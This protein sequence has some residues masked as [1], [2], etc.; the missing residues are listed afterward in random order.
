MDN[1]SI[2]NPHPRLLDGPDLLHQL[3][4]KQSGHD[5]N[6]I[7]IEHHAQNASPEIWTYTALHSA[8]NALA[9][10]LLHQRR[11]RP[12][13]VVPIFMRQC[14]DLYIAQLAILKAGAAFCPL[15]IDVPQDRLKFILQDVDASC[16]ITNEDAS[17][18]LPD[19]GTGISIIMV[20]AL[21]H[22]KASDGPDLTIEPTQPAYIM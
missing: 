3:V 6:A 11:D 4:D 20:D 9:H 14:P 18:V 5:L 1:L 13:F 2:I 17:A 19:P 12:R 16:L 22:V 21:H 8:A 15:P 10:R 7:A